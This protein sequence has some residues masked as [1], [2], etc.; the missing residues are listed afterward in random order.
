M[1]IGYARVSTT[2]QNLEQQIDLLR[3]SG[4]EK[5]YTDKKSGKNTDRPGLQEMLS[6]IREG[7]TVVIWKL[8]RLGRSTKDLIELVNLFKDKG[9]EFQSLSES[10][11]TGTAAGKLIFTIFAAFAEF[12]RE[13]I[14]ERTKLGLMNSR[15]RGRSGGRPKGLSDEAK[16]KAAAAKTFYE[17]GNLS[18]DAIAKQL[19]ISKSTLYKYLRFM[20]V[21]ISSAK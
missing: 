20:G 14:S 9:V 8:A 5:I 6:Y 2:D 21:E 16:N 4:C 17:E 10:I 15:A 11:D 13:L 19:D 3:K 7:D 18:V 12:E 1:K